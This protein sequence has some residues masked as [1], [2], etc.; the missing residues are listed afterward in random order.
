MDPN[1]DDANVYGLVTELCRR[2]IDKNAPEKHPYMPCKDD[3]GALK[4]LRSRAFEILLNK[5]PN[6]IDHDGGN[7][8]FFSFKKVFKMLND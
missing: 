3:T 6:K 2:F 5:S 1:D 4:K 8:F 7:F